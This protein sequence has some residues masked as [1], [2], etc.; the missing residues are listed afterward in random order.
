[1]VQSD[2]GSDGRAAVTSAVTSHHGC[3]ELMGT[4]TVRGTH[5]PAAFS[6]IAA[7]VAA[8][9]ETKDSMVVWS[10]LYPAALSSHV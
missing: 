6:V 8:R 9:T 7:A 1:M 3:C 5:R 4:R 10:V 2:Q